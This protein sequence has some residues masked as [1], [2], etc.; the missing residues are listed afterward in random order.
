MIEKKYKVEKMNVDD[1]VIN[2]DNPNIMTTIQ[3]ASLKYS[4]D[5]FGDVRPIVVDTKTNIL[6][7]GHHRLDVYK[8]KGIKEI[9]VFKYPFKN[10]REIRLFQQASNKIHGTHDPRLDA[11]DIF[12]IIEN[13]SKNL[14]EFMRLSAESDA[15]NIMKLLEKN[16][17]EFDHSIFGF[18]NK[19]I[20]TEENLDSIPTSESFTEPITKLGDI[21]QLGKHRLLC[22]DFDDYDDKVKPFLNNKKIDMVFVDPPY[23]IMGS[24]NGFTKMDDDN[25]L[26]PFFRNLLKC[27]KQNTKDDAHIYICCNWRTYSSIINANKSTMLTPKNLIVWHKPNARL[28]SMYSSSHEFIIFMANQPLSKHLKDETPT[29]K[30]RTVYGETNVWVYSVDTNTIREHFAQKPVV[31][32]ERAIKNSTEE[33]ETVMDMC[34]GSGS[35]LIACEQTNRICYGI[36][37][38]PRYCD[39]ICKRYEN[40]T[41]IKP[42]KLG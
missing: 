4:F 26:Q 29:H 28:G 6:A 9:E 33:G 5:K 19:T 15:N 24:S 30:T 14:S 40:L 2:P 39:V 3:Q 23:N 10:L 17:I 12:K 16:K 1:I 20:V 27:I 18:S 38:E 13:D 42:R 7:D 32:M 34:I 8:Q 11:H 41:G 25:T 35:T 36:E 22:A 37:I 31:L 21:W